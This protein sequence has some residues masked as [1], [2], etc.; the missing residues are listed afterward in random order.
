[1]ATLQAKPRFQIVTR[2]GTS[3][4][5]AVLFGVI[6][7]GLLYG[8]WSMIRMPGES[9]RGALPAAT[10]AQRALAAELETH[11]RTLAGTMGQR[12]TFNARQLAEA[13]LV[14]EGEVRGRG[15]TRCA[16]TPTSRAARPCRI[17]RW[18]FAGTETPDEIVVIGAHFDSFQGTPGA[19][20]NASGVAALLAWAAREV[21]HARAR[22]V[23]FVAFVNEEPPAFQTADMGSWV[24]AKKCRESKDNI[25]AMLSLEAIGYYRDEEGSQHYPWPLGVFLP[26]SR[27]LC[28]DGG[29]LVVARAGEGV[30][31]DV[32]EH[33]EV[34]VRGRG[35]AGLD[36]RAL[37]G[38]T[39]GRSGRRDIRR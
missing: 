29:E 1:M 17:S 21:G 37:G 26:R 4:R 27:R 3:K 28:R 19:D 36:S 6:A 7:I 22:T 8:W 10:D 15:V 16:S 32:P 33:D 5:L 11:V 25:V 24:Y 23:R 39:T 2:Q 38:R 30:S 13:G 18:R 35:A 9:F 12:S 34:P 20:D 31:R 14:C